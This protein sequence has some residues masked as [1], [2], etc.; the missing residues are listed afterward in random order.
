MN[1]YQTKEVISDMF[2]LLIEFHTRYLKLFE[3]YLLDT[4]TNP[5]D[6]CPQTPEVKQQGEK[7]GD[8]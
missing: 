5:C 1:Y 3:Q 8:F 4:I 2:D 7:E 6:Q